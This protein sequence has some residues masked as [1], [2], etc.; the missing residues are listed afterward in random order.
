MM[1]DLIFFY[2]FNPLFRTYNYKLIDIHITTAM[3]I[4]SVTTSAIANNKQEFPYKYLS[5]IS[6]K[7]K[8]GIV[9]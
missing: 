2:I 1:E 4:C 5:L 7:D 6:K 9:T 3:R 8:E